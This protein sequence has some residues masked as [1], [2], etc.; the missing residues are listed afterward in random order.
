MSKFLRALG[1]AW[2]L[3]LTVAG[4]LYACLF[5]LL[6]WYRW[7][8]KRDDAF[9]WLLNDPL[10]PWLT[11]LWAKT[12]GQAV[13]NVVVLRYDPDTDRGRTTLRH[14]QEHVH[15]AMVLG[16]ILFPI[17]YLLSSLVIKVAC[18]YSDSYYSNPFEIDAR[19]ASGQTV[20]VE[21]IFHRLRSKGKLQ[22]SD[23]KHL[24][25]QNR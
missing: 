22:A 16:G 4:A 9:V 10:P 3:P 11:L 14:E 25:S 8:G 21:G 23:M 15:Q 6:G 2:A 13:G 5:T 12:S 7:L 24:R 17:A 20:D 19:R 1:F 18:P